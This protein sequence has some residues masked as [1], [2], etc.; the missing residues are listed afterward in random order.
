MCAHG[1][2][3]VRRDES[4]I[5]ERRVTTTPPTSSMVPVLDDPLIPANQIF[6]LAFT[7]FILVVAITAWVIYR[8]YKNHV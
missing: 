7:V 6:A 5:C 2:E 4:I 1:Y 8:T 3:C